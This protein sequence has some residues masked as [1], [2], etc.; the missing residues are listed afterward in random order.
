MSC[1]YVSV[2]L[3]VCP[4]LAL[5][6]LRAL[7]CVGA[8]CSDPCVQTGFVL[9][10][11]VRVLSATSIHVMSCAVWH[12]ACVFYWL[13]AFMFSCLV[14]KRGLWVFSLAACSCPVLH[15]AGV[16]FAGHVLVF[17]F[18]VSTWLC[19]SF[20]CAMYSHVNLSW[21]PPILFPDYW[22]ICPTC[23]SSLPS[24]FAP[25]IFSLC[26]QSCASSSSNVS[27]S[28]LALP[29]PAL[30]CPALPCPA[31]CPASCP[32]FPIRGSFILLCLFFPIKTYSPV[33]ASFL[34]PQPW[35]KCCPPNVFHKGV[36]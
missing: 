33:L 5:S 20:L 26:L 25:F 3:R 36:V 2:Q 11:T 18:C 4:S 8:W 24:S 19:L 14:W 30:P 6:R 7:F 15:M 16:L 13:R 28:C 22:L 12:A 10:H 27:C 9:L 17:L 32:D 29:C 23:L 34:H 31:S 21:T 1:F 35:Q